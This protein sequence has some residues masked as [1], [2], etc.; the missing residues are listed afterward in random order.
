MLRSHSVIRHAYDNVLSASA[1]LIS[2][3]TGTPTPSH[4]GLINE[5]QVI[6]AAEDLVM[7]AVHA[8]RLIENTASHKRCSEIFIPAVFDIQIGKV[9][10]PITRIINMFIHHNHIQ[11]VSFSH[12]LWSYHHVQSGDIS[13]DDFA[14]LHKNIRH[15]SPHV[16]VESDH[17]KRAIFELRPLI[18][19]FETEVLNPI[20]ELCAKD[21]LYLEDFN[22]ES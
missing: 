19:I 5:R 6:L 16:L 18:E 21:K 7:F 12:E 9:P 10:V 22:F 11:I 4:D 17:G 13:A 3:A 2:F 8:R 15:F 1:R 14:A 20:V